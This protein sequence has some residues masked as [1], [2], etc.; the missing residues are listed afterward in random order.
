MFENALSSIFPRISV[1]FIMV[2][3]R[4]EYFFPLKEGLSDPNDGVNQLHW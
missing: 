2:T 1:L 3:L 4:S